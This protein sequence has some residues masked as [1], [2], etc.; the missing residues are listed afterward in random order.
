MS[1]IP[2]IRRL[3][4]EE[5][6]FKASLDYKVRSCLK[7]KS[8]LNS[9]FWTNGVVPAWKGQGP[10]FKLQYHQKSKS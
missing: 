8:F 7:K 10:E 4:Q 5:P 3:R 2:E 9:F 1:V 6:R